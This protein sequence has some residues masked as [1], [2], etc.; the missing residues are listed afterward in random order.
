MSWQEVVLVQYIDQYIDQYIEG[1]F[2]WLL[3]FSVLSAW[4]LFRMGGFPV[5]W[6]ARGDPCLAAQL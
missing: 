2:W 5:S 6:Q 3:V 4:Q 1:V